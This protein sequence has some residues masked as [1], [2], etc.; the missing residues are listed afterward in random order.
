[1]QKLLM[2][3]LLIV[4]AGLLL[5]RLRPGERQ[6]PLLLTHVTII[7]VTNG[8]LLPD[9]AV[10]IRDGRI[11]KVRPSA[12]A[13]VADEAQIIDATG[14]FL[15]PGFW[16]MHVHV[17]REKRVQKAFP[18]LLANGVLGIRDMGSP[19]NE[20]EVKEWHRRIDEGG[21]VAPRLV[22]SGPMIDGAE[23]MFPQISIAAK[24]ETEA[25]QD[26]V[27]LK[28][29]GA[30][31][32]KVYSRL[33]RA[34]YFAVAEE[35]KRQ[36]LPF[37]GHVPDRVSAREASDAGQKSLEH[38]SGVLLA[39]STSEAELRK[40]L[41][42]AGAQREPVDHYNAL[43]RIQKRSEETFSK[44]KA[45]VLFRRFAQ[46]ETWQ[47][48]TLVGVWNLRDSEA[49][50][51]GFENEERVRD[52][53]LGMRA[54]GVEFMAGTDAPNL[55]AEVGQSLH[56]ELALFVRAGFTPLEALQTATVNPAK[57][58]GL[59][60]SLGTV[61]EGKIADLVLLDGNP[62]DDITNTQK[63]AAVILRGQLIGKAD[64]E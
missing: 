36:G 38:L 61:E 49:N 57:Y 47:V 40:E 37:A 15:T 44:E 58:L 28:A 3:L 64:F 56:K 16:D 23:P 62:L 9:M 11:V 32:I 24:T 53:L 50:G 43:K 25:R 19:V 42:Q 10:E 29:S 8:Q 26:V 55:W 1:M 54:A 41:R 34:A 31:F 4:L 33:S 14:K 45:A 59:L 21:L 48:P 52:L 60:D 13:A 35:A 22:A 30:D 17:L 51:A 6:Y 20:S 39:C 12:D 46:N 5:V 27:F 63:I 2:M 7:D 18:L